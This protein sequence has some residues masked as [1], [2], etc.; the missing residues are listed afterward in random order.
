MGLLTN[1]L[2]LPLAPVRFTVWVAE[3]VNEET[4]R[5]RASPGAVAQRLAALEEAR[6]RGDLDAEDAERLQ[7]EVIEQVARPVSEP[8]KEDAERG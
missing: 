8:G 7:G 5:R 2:L 4:E 6:E 3:Q 1:L